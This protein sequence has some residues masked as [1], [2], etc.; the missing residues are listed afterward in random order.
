MGLRSAAVRAFKWSLLGEIAARL[1]GPIAFVVLARLLVPE[2]FGVVAAATVAVSFSQI[3]FDNGLSRALVH[4]QADDQASIDAA[5]VVN[6]VLG[7]ML[8]LGMLVCAPGLAEFFNDS[9]IRDVLRVLSLQLPVAAL[10][11]VVT[12]LMY[13]RLDFRRLFWVRLA[14]AGIPGLASIPLAFAGLSYWALVVGAL[15]GQLTQL[16]LLWRVASWSTNW[17][18][19][20]SAARQLIR[21]G[22]WSVASGLLGWLYGWLDVI[23]VGHYLG[24]HDMGL[25]RTGNTLVIAVFGLMFAPL[26]PVL[27]SAFSRQQKELERL[28]EALRTVTHAIALV[29]VPLGV[30]LFTM[31]S[32]LGE[33]VLG[34]QWEGVGV[35]IAFL[36]ISH[37]VGWIAGANGE[38]YRAIGKPHVETYVMAL[39]LAAY[40]PTYLVA[41]RYGLES[42]LWARVGLSVAA[43]GVHI[44]VCHRVIGIPPGH[45][46]RAGS[47]A[48]L[49]AIAAAWLSQQL[50]LTN[51]AAATHIALTTI[52]GA[53]AYVI[54]IVGLEREFL[55]RLWRIFRDSST[56]TSERG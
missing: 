30:A 21:F 48:A 2:D 8:M 14:S 5:I 51:N 3:F 19:D 36:G 28:R 39:L 35:V 52:L 6:L 47:W 9:R 37:A 33:L 40:V 54:A 55:G 44:V 1:T 43:L 23:V 46:L 50:D 38:L 53:A 25:Y 42:F 27:Y 17:I 20:W 41:V 49:A 4:L 32:D 16:V 10:C 12:A 11:S 45:W 56:T 31:S 34:A 18:I 24:S 7:L 13:K 15:V 22:R 26:L 29:S